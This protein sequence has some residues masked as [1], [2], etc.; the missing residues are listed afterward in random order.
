M[1]EITR[2]LPCYAGPGIAPKM[3]EFSGFEIGSFFIHHGTAIHQQRFRGDWTVTH[4]GSGYSVQQSLPSKKRAIWLA[5]KLE[6]V[7]DWGF[8]GPD[9][10]RELSKHARNEINV[11][12]ADAM[13]GDCQGSMP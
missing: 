1:K 3:I 10:A 11:L 13:S 12:R 5:K 7:C 2:M 8:S 9:G 6:P 4:K